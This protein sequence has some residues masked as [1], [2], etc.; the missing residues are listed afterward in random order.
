MMVDIPRITCKVIH[1]ELRARLR[2][3][4]DRLNCRASRDSLIASRGVNQMPAAA[5]VTVVPPDP[6]WPDRAATEL[7]AIRAALG[8]L[9]VHAD[10]IGST[11]IPQMPAKDVLDLQ[12]SVRDLTAAAAAFDEPLA[13][14]GY[15][16][17]SY[18]H[19]HVPA[20]HASDPQLWIK[21]YWSR[22]GHRDGDVN[23]HVRL[24]GSPN[25]R[26]ALL[27]RDWLRA[28]PDALAAYGQFKLVLAAE[29]PDLDAYTD[30]K[31]PVVDVVIA[32]ATE[33]ASATGWQPH[34]ADPER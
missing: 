12:L 22:R 34:G 11:S 19:D 33:W 4:P 15:R 2:A 20:G 1:D 23:L 32:A 7:A 26:L 29:V 30:I 14:R 16:R 18:E 13:L 27:F 25:E 5:A 3:R 21:R 8:P 6:R 24:A 28:H 17:L 31:D 9:V 10:H